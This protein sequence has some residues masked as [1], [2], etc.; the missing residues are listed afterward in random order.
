MYPQPKLLYMS[1]L[2]GF[3]SLSSVSAIL[4]PAKI[5]DGP[6]R[7]DARNESVIDRYRRATD[8]RDQ[9]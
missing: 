3:A 6:I 1:I 5:Q 2:A 4:D 8:V 7:A 9:V